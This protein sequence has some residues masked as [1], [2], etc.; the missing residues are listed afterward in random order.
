M[1]LDYLYIMGTSKLTVCEELDNF[2]ILNK[3]KKNL[4]T[5]DLISD[6][7]ISGREKEISSW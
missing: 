1:F 2:K 6:K 3:I 7:I 5:F 4:Y